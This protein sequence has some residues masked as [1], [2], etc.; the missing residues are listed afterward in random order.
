[1]ETEYEIFESLQDRTVIWRG[2]ACG[3][4]A[5]LATLEKLSK[6]TENELFA[7][8]LRSQTVIARANQAQAD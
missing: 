4:Q 8:H 3:T 1:M 2:C 6:Q 5:A 7:I